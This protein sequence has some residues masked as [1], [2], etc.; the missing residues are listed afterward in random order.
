MEDL[1]STQTRCT[2][3]SPLHD[4]LGIP[5]YSR[6]VFPGRLDAL[7]RKLRRNSAAFTDLEQESFPGF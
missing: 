3:A 4:Q 7:F 5:L 6:L 1:Q 2:E